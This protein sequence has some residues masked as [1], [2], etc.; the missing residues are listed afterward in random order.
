[1]EM[2]ALFSQGAFSQQPHCPYKSN[3][4]KPIMK[5]IGVYCQGEVTSATVCRLSMA[6][7]GSSASSV[8]SGWTPFALPS[9]WNT[10]PLAGLVLLL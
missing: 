2:A 9:A 10:A 3:Q 6:L 8:N 1:M 4:D 5:F 7:P